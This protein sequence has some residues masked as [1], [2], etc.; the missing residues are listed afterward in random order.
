LL[1]PA[2]RRHVLQPDR[3]RQQGR[4]RLVDR[5]HSVRRRHDPDHGPL[6]GLAVLAGERR[7]AGHDLSRGAWI[8]R[9][10][11]SSRPQVPPEAQAGA[12]A[13]AR[14]MSSLEAR[15]R[16][17]RRS[18]TRTSAVR[19][20]L[21]ALLAAAAWVLAVLFAARLMP[22]DQVVRIAAYGVPIA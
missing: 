5:C 2:Q 6:P 12:L 3:H 4:H 22:I 8:Q 14:L 10:R 13:C 15:V 16:E 9:A 19:Y 7:Y 1:D 20:L 11:A 17:L 21:H 18:S